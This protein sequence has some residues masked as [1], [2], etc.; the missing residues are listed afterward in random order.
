[1][2]HTLI[3]VA[4]L[5]SAVGGR[6]AEEVSA[7]IKQGLAAE[8]KLD[9]RAALVF[10]RQADAAKPDDPV[11]LQKIAQQLSDSTALTASKEE[12][13]HLAA[14]ALP[15]AQRAMALAP[16]SAVNVLSVA[17]CYGKLALDAGTRVKIEDSRLVKGYAE[18][19]LVLDPNYDWAHHVLARWH[20]EVADLGF[21]D[22]LALR[23]VYGG[24]PSATLTEAIAHFKRAVELAPT[25]PSHHIELAFALLA[26][27]RKADARVEFQRGLDLPAQ[28]VFDNE[29]KDRARAALKKLK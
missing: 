28:G 23:V 22:R 27:G 11:I 16:K 10:F 19:A 15:F 4:L 3:L 7:L 5:T 6:G 25:Q 12:R 9:P 8:A 14:E 1:M 21:A 26:D 29:T 2:K 18:E 24:L 20:T 17:I 13:Q